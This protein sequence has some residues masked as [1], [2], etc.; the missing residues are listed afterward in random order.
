MIELGV[1]ITPHRGVVSTSNWFCVSPLSVIGPKSV[2]F[3]FRH[4][5]CG[6]QK[7]L[8]SSQ[9]LPQTQTSSGLGSLFHNTMVSL[10]HFM[11]STL[12]NIISA[13]N[14]QTKMVRDL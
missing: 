5:L 6:H 10:L 2:G 14:N 7:I 8:G 1:V 13:G 3:F 12:S 4:S 11:Y 9:F